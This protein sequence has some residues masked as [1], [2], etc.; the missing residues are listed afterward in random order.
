MTDER[1]HAT[2]VPP[3]RMRTMVTYLEMTAPPARPHPPTPLERLALLRAEHCT[4]SFYRFLYNTVGE[5]WLWWSRRAMPDAA[6]QALL[7]DER[8][9]IYVPY[10]AGVPAGFVELDRRRP[11]TCEIAYFGLMPDFIGRRLGPWLLGW[12]VEAGWKGAGTTRMTV[13]TCTLDH[14]KALMLYQRAG[15]LPVRQVE[16]EEPDPRLTGLLPRHAAPH[17]PLVEG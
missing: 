8:V 6:L 2:P 14:P 1:T 5:P 13:N 11:G 9:E 3:G 10:V 7:A 17:V 16:K 15:F 4:L 12:A